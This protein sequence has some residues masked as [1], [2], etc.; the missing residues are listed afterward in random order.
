[1]L[2]VVFI[3][4][5]FLPFCPTMRVSNAAVVTLITKTF[6]FRNQKYKKKT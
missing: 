6:Q 5:V 1:M 4:S 3:G 2:N